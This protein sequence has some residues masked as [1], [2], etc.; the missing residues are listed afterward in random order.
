MALPMPTQSSSASM[1][2]PNEGESAT[3]LR[4]N[5]RGGAWAQFALATLAM[6]GGLVLPGATQVAQAQSNSANASSASTSNAKPSRVRWTPKPERGN[7]RGT[8]SGG[9]RGGDTVACGPTADDTA[10]NLLVTDARESLITTQAQPTLAWQV[11]TQQPVEM[12]LIVSDVSQ[13]A[14]LFTQR[15]V[16]NESEVIRV[17]LPPAA[18]LS[19]GAQYRWTV[20]AQCPT[21][22][23]SEIYARSFI[24]QVSG[25]SLGQQPSVTS[26][27]GQLPLDQAVAYA[28]SGVWY[29]AVAQL[30]TLPEQVVQGQP[31]DLLAELLEQA[32]TSTL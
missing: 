11:K 10:L 1:T 30:L 27:L 5:R 21:G 25:E 8:L 20:V 18:A 29:D 14:P 19:P 26:S 2:F 9:R 28:N 23:K 15:L 31:A 22:Q 16:A 17:E 3:S 32:Q 24:R 12:E 6:L 4:R 7:A 13:A